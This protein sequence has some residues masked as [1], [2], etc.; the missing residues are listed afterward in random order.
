M[1]FFAAVVGIE[2]DVGVVGDGEGGGTGIGIIFIVG[3]G[4]I[5]GVDFVHNG[6]DGFVEGGDH[7]GVGGVVMDVSGVVVKFVPFDIVGQGRWSVF[8]VGLAVADDKVVDG[9]VGEIEI[10]GLGCFIDELEG[11]YGEGVGDIFIIVIWLGF[12]P[13]GVGEV[14]AEEAGND[15][16]VPMVFPVV[17]GDTAADEIVEAVLGQ[18]RL[19][20]VGAGAGVEA[21]GMKFTDEEGGVIFLVAEGFGDG[22]GFEGELASGKATDKGKV[23]GI[24]PLGDVIGGKGGPL[25]AGGVLSGTEADAGGGTLGAGIGV[26]EADAGVAEGG[27]VGCLVVGGVELSGGGRGAVGFAA[28][29]V[30]PA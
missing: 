1:D 11:F 7:G 24:L 2:D 21:V 22:D 3:V 20:G 25:K 15:S 12:S 13:V 26:G 18:V 6:T 30:G 4:L 23:L 28:V 8:G 14:G 9:A 29:D 19:E 17:A 27:E 5:G 10:I 16:V